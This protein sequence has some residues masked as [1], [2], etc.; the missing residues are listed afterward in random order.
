MDFLDLCQRAA[1]YAQEETALTER[2]QQAQARGEGNEVHQLAEE[3]E[4]AR[5]ERRIALGEAIHFQRLG[6]PPSAR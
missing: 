1:F 2:R 3:L 5:V 4:A 6:K